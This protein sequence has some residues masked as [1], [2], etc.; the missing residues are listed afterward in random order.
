M[1]NL[2]SDMASSGILKGGSD[3]DL[4]KAFGGGGM[5]P[6]NSLWNLFGINPTMMQLFD[7]RYGAP[8]T[9]TGEEVAKERTFDYGSAPVQAGLSS[10]MGRFQRPMVS[11]FQ[12]RQPSSSGLS[13]VGQPVA[14]RQQAASS[15][16]DRMNMAGIKKPTGQTWGGMG[17]F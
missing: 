5:H 11:V 2:F 10:D 9:S 4:V 15:V 16:L 1:G 14:S 6:S 7:S 17:A 12:Q 3:S 13:S 8:M